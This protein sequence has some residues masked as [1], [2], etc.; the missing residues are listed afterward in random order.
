MEYSE[1][2]QCSQ[3]RPARRA[4]ASFKVGQQKNLKIIKPIDQICIL[5]YFIACILHSQMTESVIFIQDLFEPWD[6][7]LAFVSSATNPASV[8]HYLVPIL[9]VYNVQLATEL[10][11]AYALAD[12]TN[13]LLKWPLKGDRPYWVIIICS[14]SVRSW[15]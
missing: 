11:S 1:N 13:L 10:V 7:F 6:D 3:A 14:L 15:P 5:Y 2:C 8:L 12:V 4:P 9:S